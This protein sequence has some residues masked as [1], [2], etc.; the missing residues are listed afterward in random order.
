MIPFPAKEYSIIYADPP[1]AYGQGGRGAAKDHYATMTTEEL[2]N[3]PV[4]QIAGGLLASCG[5][6]SQTSARR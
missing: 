6:H 4:T 1:W 3:M 2:C 5:Q